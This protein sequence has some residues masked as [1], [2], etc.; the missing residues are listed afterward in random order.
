MLP[1]RKVGS[2]LSAESVQIFVGKANGGQRS[3]GVGQDAEGGDARRTC[4]ARFELAVCAFQRSGDGEVAGN[5]RGAT[6]RRQ[7]GARRNG[8]AAAGAHGIPAVADLPVERVVLRG[9]CREDE[10]ERFVCCEEARAVARRVR[11]EQIAVCAPRVL[12]RGR[13]AAQSPARAAPSMKWTRAA[14]S[15]AVRR[16]CVFFRRR[17]RPQLAAGLSRRSDGNCAALLHTGRR[18]AEHT[19]IAIGA[20]RER[21]DDMLARRVPYSTS[22]VPLNRQVPYSAAQGVHFLPSTVSRHCLRCRIRLTAAPHDTRT[23]SSASR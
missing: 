12:A 3:G 1:G 6:E 8:K 5:G 21:L 10:R 7:R 20:V 18:I 4:A 23:A 16:R 13:G 19:V 2:A 14:G 17:Q 15:C 11:F 9:S 22:R